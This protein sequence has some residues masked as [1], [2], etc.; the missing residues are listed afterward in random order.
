MK[1]NSH[2]LNR[3]FW[4]PLASV[5]NWIGSFI[6]Q[7]PLE[8]KAFQSPYMQGHPRPKKIRLSKKHEHASSEAKGSP[9][10]ETKTF[11]HPRR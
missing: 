1:K 9:H 6:N 4:W 8:K 3:Y 7:R 5:A 10:A 2:I 11:N